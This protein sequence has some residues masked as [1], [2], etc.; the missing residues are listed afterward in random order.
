MTQPHIL[1]FDWDGTLINSLEIKIA[2]AGIV[3]EAVLGL[4]QEGVLAAYRRHSGIP[5]RQLFSA[6]CDENN[7]PPLDTQQ[8][9]TLSQRFSELNMRF[10][11]N[12]ETPG[13]VPKDTQAILPVL[14]D[15]GHPL[16][17]SSSAITEEL[18]LIAHAHGLDAYFHQI[19]GSTPGFNKGCSIIKG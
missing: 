12:P 10:L 3:F 18:N 11:T 1:L 5:R 6:I 8:Y 15:S 16:Y 14:R 7:H 2:N 17:V 9:Q 19:M 4:P 13:L